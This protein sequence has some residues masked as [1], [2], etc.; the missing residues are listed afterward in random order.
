MSVWNLKEAVEVP[1]YGM[2][3]WDI[4]LCKKL[5]VVCCILRNMVLDDS[6]TRDNTV[7]V[8]CG[9]PVEG[10]VIWLG[11]ETNQPRA[12]H[13]HSESVA[14]VEWMKGRNE[15]SKHVEFMAWRETRRIMEIDWQL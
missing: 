6:E 10:D 11:N 9:S 5:F 1:E 14:A 8:G 7:R 13:S 15:L 3:F 4:R 2:R 12:P